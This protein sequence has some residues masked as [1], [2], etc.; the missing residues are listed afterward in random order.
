[1]KQVIALC[2]LILA[3]CNGLRRL[4]GTEDNTPDS[5]P[6]QTVTYQEKTFYI[7]VKANNMIFGYANV[8]SGAVDHVQTW[9]VDNNRNLTALDYSHFKWMGE[10]KGLWF[11]GVGSYQ[12][13]KVTLYFV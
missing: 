10:V 6:I 3:G 5:T 4:E 9:G 11:Y 8:L 13:V 2:L 7:E 12:Y 1:M